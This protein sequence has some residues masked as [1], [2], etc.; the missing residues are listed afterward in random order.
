MGENKLMDNVAVFG[1][2]PSGLAA[3]HAAYLGGAFV[4]I[5][6]R[7]EKSE[8]HGCQYLHAPIP[9]LGVDVPQTTVSYELQGTPAEYRE[10]VYGPEYDGAVSVD[11]L[12][13]KHAAW[14]IRA[15]YDRLWD[16]YMAK[17]RG[18]C[19]RVDIELKAKFVLT[20]E[21]LLKYDAVLSTIPA[22]ALCVF[23]MSHA[24]ESQQIWAIGDALD[25][26]QLA[27]F[28]A[29][30]DT[31]MCSGEESPSWY[32]ASKVFDVATVEWPER[33]KPPIPGIVSVLKP[34]GTT[35]DCVPF[36]TRLGR[37]GAW[38]KG[39]LTHHVFDKVDRMMKNGK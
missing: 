27:P 39:Q 18:R 1:S 28:G 3:A 19:N 20:S 25:G 32:R 21:T 30:P 35:C 6:S 13:G 38:D 34:L 23:P 31:V 29:P 16:L 24:F 11:S 26:S 14:D 10:K 9:E 33:T 4:T 15:T 12:T 2:G 5:Y 37:Y 36:I 17:P 22:P 7:G 8:L